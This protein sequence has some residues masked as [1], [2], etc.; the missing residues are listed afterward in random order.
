MGDKI[1][2]EK[3]IPLIEKG[4]KEKYP[5]KSMEIGDS[6]I[7]GDYSR[8]NMQRMNGSISAYRKKHAPLSRF[9]TRRIDNQI[10]VWRIA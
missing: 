8:E 6:F 1:K 9:A 5:L 10:R 7:M 3:N 2:I 4:N